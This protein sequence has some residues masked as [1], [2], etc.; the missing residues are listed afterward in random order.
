MFCMS[1]YGVKRRCAGRVVGDDPQPRLI[2]LG[3]AFQPLGDEAEPVEQ[4]EDAGRSLQAL[5]PSDSD[6]LSADVINSEFSARAQVGR[7]SP[8]G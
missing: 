1:V 5:W 6:R 4:H 8:A 3:D 7:I 2:A